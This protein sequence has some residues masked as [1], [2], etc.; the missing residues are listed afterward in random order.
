MEVVYSSA[1]VVRQI[2]ESLTVSY[3]ECC[4]L[5]P[6][7]LSHIS[8]AFKTLDLVP[9]WSLESSSLLICGEDMNGCK[10]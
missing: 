4:V 6:A 2:S 5:P 7:F 10:L 9:L 8:E 3:T 1:E